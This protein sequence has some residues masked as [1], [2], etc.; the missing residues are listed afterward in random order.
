MTKRFNLQVQ[1]S[2]SN[3][4][5]GG[6]FV[7]I[8]GHAEAVWRI[9]YDNDTLSFVLSCYKAPA[10]LGDTALMPL[11]YIIRH[12]PNTIT[13]LGDA[14]TIYKDVLKRKMFLDNGNDDHLYFHII[15]HFLKNNCFLLSKDLKTHPEKKHV[16]D[17]VS[18]DKLGILY[19]STN[20][21]VTY[22]L[23]SVGGDLQMYGLVK[24]LREIILKKDNLNSLYSR[25]PI[26]VYL[27]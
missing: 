13:K 23:S 8:K 5:Y 20:T 17:L 11:K 26:E 7:Y 14:S 10:S 22:I 18:N 15:G 25:L 6:D 12:C 2:Q 1:D 27:C 19:K 3:D 9:H 16:V 4:L 21:P 24:E